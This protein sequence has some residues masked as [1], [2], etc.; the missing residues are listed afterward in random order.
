ML[1]TDEARYLTKAELYVLSPHMCDV[2]TVAA[3]TLNTDDLQQLGEE[4][5]PSPTGLV[6]FPHPVCRR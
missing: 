3:L 5:L 6:I 4:D 2:M 1:V